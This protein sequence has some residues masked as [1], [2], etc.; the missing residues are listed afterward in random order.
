MEQ[1]AGAA[2]APSVWKTD[3]LTVIRYLRLARPEGFEPPIL[4]VVT[5]YSIPLN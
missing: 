2:P 5:A 1:I 4:R 3:I